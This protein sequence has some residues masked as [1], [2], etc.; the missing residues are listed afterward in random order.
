MSKM[1]RRQFTSSLLAVAAASAIRPAMAQ[2]RTGV[3]RESIKIGVLGSLTGPQA[4]FGTGQ[5]SGA[6]LAFEAVN[7]QGGINGRKIE[8]V[9]IDDESSAPK[10]IAGFHRLVEA[11]KVFAIF[12]PSTS[13][14]AQPLVPAITANAQVPIF[15]CIAS[16]PALTEPL[17]KNVFRMGTLNDRLQ[18]MTIANFVLD[19]LKAK[20]VALIRQSDEYGRRGGGGVTQCMQDRK[21]GLVA[22]E[23]FNISD[24]DFTAQLLRIREAKPDA[25]IMYGFPA[26]AATITRQTRQ[27][28]IT[29]KIVGSNATSSRTYPQTVGPAVVGAM[30]VTCLQAL[31]E[32][33]EPQMVA[34]RDKFTARFPDLAR[35][36][37]P[38]IGDATGYGGALTL[39]E[40]LRRAGPDPTRESFMSA[41]EG[42]QNFATGIT[43][44]TSF[45][46]NNREGNLSLRIVEFQPD[47][48]RKLIPAIIKAPV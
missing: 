32:G 3:A 42:M 13:A 29:A 31:P 10:A 33:N 38:D 46:P 27:F 15:L 37:R 4:V 24:T 16:T 44:P 5:L 11:D 48:T 28:G 47:L 20:R 26:A 43:L 18:G 40:G 17:L 1:T 41:L 21:T 7:A 25:M 9:V 35:Q 45:G 22:D 8:A 2:N 23:V 30:N 19:E 12:G 6:Q 14:M 36:N 39:I 34:Y